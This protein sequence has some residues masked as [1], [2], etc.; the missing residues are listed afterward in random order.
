VNQST[1]RALGLLAFLLLGVG[2]GVGGCKP[3]E[4][5]AGVAC[6]AAGGACAIPNFQVGPLAPSSAQDCNPTESPA[7]ITCYFPPMAADAGTA[8]A[9]LRDAS[10]GACG[11]PAIYD[12]TDA[13]VATGQCVAAR[14]YLSCKGSNGGGEDCLSNDPTQCPG[15]DLTPGVTYSN[16]QDQCDSNEYALGCGGP[17]PGPWPQPPAACRPLS[18][19]PGGGT[20]ACCPCVGV[21]A[22]VPEPPADAA[23]EVASTDQ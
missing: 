2:A 13:S 11:W 21:D 3:S 16:C 17:G 14:A 4:P 9:S 6:R 15:P 7:G 22:A 10:L 19:G 20:S 18:S 1:S 8:D 23:S 5:A 12:A